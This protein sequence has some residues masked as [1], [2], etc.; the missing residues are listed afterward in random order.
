M[1]INFLK[2]KW[3][4]IRQEINEDDYPDIVSSNNKPEIA[5]WWD[6]ERNYLREFNYFAW[7]WLRD[8]FSSANDFVGKI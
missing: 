1:N 3:L 6:Y 4:E 5:I 2:Q 8:R 7:K